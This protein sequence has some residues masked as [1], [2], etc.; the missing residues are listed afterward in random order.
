VKGSPYF[1]KNRVLTEEFIGKFL[2][3][4]DKWSKHRLRNRG[5]E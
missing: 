1:W 2:I 4:G 5:L 3:D